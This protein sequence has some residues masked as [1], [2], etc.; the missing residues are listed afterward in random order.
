MQQ[1]RD[2][3]TTAKTKCFYFPFG[4]MGLN[5]ILSLAKQQGKKYSPYDQLKKRVERE[6][7]VISRS[8]FTG[9]IEGLNQYDFHW[10]RTNKRRDPDNLSSSEKFFLDAF[11][12][13]KIIAND[14]WG[15]IGFL[16]HHFGQ[17][18]KDCLWLEVTPYEKTTKPLGF[19]GEVEV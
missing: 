16:Q 12:A 15:E 3:N 13:V 17:F 2:Y 5:E 6:I 18:T 19:L 4:T 1:L 10:L 9:K 14:G 11:R 7:A 8:Q